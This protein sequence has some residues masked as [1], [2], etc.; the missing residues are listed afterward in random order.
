MPLSTALIAKLGEI[1]G[2]RHCLQGVER[3][4]YVVEGRTPELVVF[5]GCPEEIAQILVLASEERVSVVPWGGGTKMTLGSPPRDV[6][7]VLGTK[8][9]NRLLEHEP[10]DM[11]ATVQAGMTLDALQE[12][13][14]QRGQWLSL[15]P[16]QGALATLGGVLAA[17]ASGPRRHLYGTARDLVIGVKVVGADG[18]IIRSG[19][20]V[21]KNVAGYDLVK[22]YIGSLGTLGIISEVSVRL[23]SLPEDD[24]T[25][26]AGF[27]TIDQ[28]MAAI[29]SIMASD[30][31]PHSL[32]MVDAV[33]SRRLL[34]G[35]GFTDDQCTL[36]VG[37]DGLREQVSWQLEEVA[38]LC[39]KE[40]QQFSRVLGGEERD[41]VW[42]R[43]RNAARG[44]FP[45]P[46]AA[47]KIGLLSTHLGE[48][49]KKGEGIA[50]GHGLLGAFT[51]HAGV[52]I[53]TLVLAPSGGLEESVT[54]VTLLV[55]QEL[56]E[57]A[58]GLGGHMALEWAPLGIKEQVSVWDPPGPAF[59]IMQS[60]KSKLDPEGILNPGRFFGGI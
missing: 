10:G 4:P 2:P 40:G 59:R 48:F 57:L 51:A 32:E 37:F 11:T 7:L 22:L 24:R 3:S 19:G 41:R 30:L 54:K 6:G 39:E 1:V 36:L 33:A 12:A 14:G 20:K 28:A 43:V 46:L 50:R 23:R 38:R 45:E 13:L 21:V 26:L 34:D 18:N 15:D 8:R 17:N 47:A 56:R 53:L 60:I 27:P 35:A 31:I 9:L 58:R 49:I 52:G 55:L 42:G 16:P 29:R 5:P 44:T 25:F